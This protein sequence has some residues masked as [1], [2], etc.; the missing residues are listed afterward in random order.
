M[1]RTPKAQ[2][3]AWTLG[4]LGAVACVAGAGVAVAFGAPAVFLLVYVVGILMGL[5]GALIAS[6]EA[7][8]GIGWLMCATALATS[9]VHVP[10]GYGYFALVTVRGAWPLGSVAVW[11][12]AWGWV[13]VLGVSL[14]LIAVRFPDGKAPSRWR[15]VDGLAIG[16]TT[17]FALAIALGRTNVLLD[18]LPIPGPSVAVLTSVVQNPL[19]IT[20]PEVLLGQ[21]QGTGLSL[22]M[23]GY[24]G[25]AAAVTA[26]FRRARGD[27][28]VQLKWFAYSG[29][30][31]AMTFAYGGVAWNFFGQPLYLALTPLMVAYLTLPLAIGVAI[32]RYRLYDIDLIINRTLVYVGVTAILGALYAAVITFLQR[33]FIS[34][35]GRRSDAAYVLTAFVVVVAFSPVKDTLQRRVDRRLARVSPTALLDKFRE[36]VDAVVSVMDVH[37]VAC[38]LVDQA[39][40][41][42][43][44]R[45]AALYL[46]PD[47]ATKPVYTRGHLNG[48]VVVEVPLRHEGRM[49]GRLALGGRRGDV[50]Y[51]TH[52]RDALQRSADSVGEALALAEHLGHRPLLDFRTEKEG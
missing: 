13:L 28:R 44:A 50:S 29:V 2:T 12:G 4:L 46:L 17:L 9:L 42:F 36:D 47:D 8:N 16:G 10:V 27:E 22:I 1:T 43:N 32:L 45:G 49:L 51:S 39:V 20:L 40:V 37:R 30:L 21:V 52:D 11:L 3:L 6:R 5:L 26:R 15:V 38:R 23:L 19:G 35:S 7:H 34:T 41:A 14:P 18:F 48:G 31:I 24:L 25:A 33:L